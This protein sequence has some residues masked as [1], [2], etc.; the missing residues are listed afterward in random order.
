MLIE[1]KVVNTNGVLIIPELVQSKQD[2]KAGNILFQCEWN[3]NFIFVSAGT[4][5]LLVDFL[6]GREDL[7]RD[8][9][10]VPSTDSDVYSSPLKSFREQRLNKLNGL[11]M[12]TRHSKKLMSVSPVGEK[13]MLITPATDAITVYEALPGYPNFVWSR[14]PDVTPQA[15]AES[16]GS[17]VARRGLEIVNAFDESTQITSL[18]VSNSGLGRRILTSVKQDILAAAKAQF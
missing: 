18:P 6:L 9:E 13:A 7:V 8:A 4:E 14:T 5:M 1:K 16:Y 12:G 17:F 2:I 10:S 15:L 3:D 11:Y